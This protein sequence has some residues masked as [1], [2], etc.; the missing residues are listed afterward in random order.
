MAHALSHPELLKRRRVLTGGSS[1]LALWLITLPPFTVGMWSRHGAAFYLG[2]IIALGWIALLP[3]AA[4]GRRQVAIALPI[5][6]ALAFFVTLLTIP[7]GSAPFWVYG[8]STLGMLLMTVPKVRRDHWEEHIP[9]GHPTGQEVTPPPAPPP[10]LG[11]HL[12]G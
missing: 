2:I 12:P 1:T 7:F 6:A 11:S 3:I 10:R 4:F 8:W 9:D 5:F